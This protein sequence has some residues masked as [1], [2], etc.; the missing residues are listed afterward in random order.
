MRKPVNTIHIRAGRTMALIVALVALQ[1]CAPPQPHAF[2]DPFEQYELGKVYDCGDIKVG[3]ARLNT[4]NAA[5]PGFGC[6]HQSNLTV[7]VSDP[8]DLVRPR[9]MTPPDA[10]A[11]QRVL[12]AYRDGSDTTAAP[13]ARGT[14]ELIQ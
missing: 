1:G 7:M 5:T 2:H 4:Q 8:A 9:E 6:S 13:A 12:E 11:R 14:R 10:Q 3:D